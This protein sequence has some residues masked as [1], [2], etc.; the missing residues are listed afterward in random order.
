MLQATPQIQPE[1]FVDFLRSL[2]GSHSRTTHL[3][4]GG[5]LEED[6]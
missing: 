3:F 2:L 4:L 5:N 1:S 6:N